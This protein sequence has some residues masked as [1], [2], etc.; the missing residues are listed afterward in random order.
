MSRRSFVFLVAGTMILFLFSVSSAVVP[1]KIN[2]QGKLATSGGGC[3]NDTVAMTFTIYSDDQGTVVDWT[4]DQDSVIVKEGIFNVLLGSVV[5]IPASVFDGSTKYLGV[6]VES[7]PEMRPLKPMVS[8]AYAYKSIETDTADFAWMA[9][10]ADLLDGQHAS[11]FLSTANDYGRSGVATDLYEETTT[12]TDKYVNE[13][14]PETVN[15]TSGTAFTG[16][17]S[18]SS[19]SSMYG[20]KGYAENTS[21]GGAYGGRFETESSGTGAHYGIEVLSSGSSSYGTYGVAGYVENSSDGDVYGGYFN[22]QA[23][24]TGTSY[25]VYS[26]SYN[27]SGGWHYGVYGWATNTSTGY[28]K[29]GYFLA[30]STGTGHPVGVWGE[31]NTSTSGLSYGIIGEASN[32]SS[33]RAVGGL[34]YTPGPIGIGGRTGIE[35]SV[36]DS[37]EVSTYGIDCLSSNRST[38]TVYGGYFDAS[39][40]LTGTGTRYGI[41]ASA[42]ADYG[43]AGYFSGDVRIT[44]SLVVL[45]GKSAAVK[46]DNGEYRLLYS[47]ESPEVW[48]E[49][50]GEGRLVNGKAVIQID[51]LFAQTVN[52]SVKYHVFLTPQDEPLTLA[53]A[54]RT[55]ASFEVIGPSG[56]NI[57]FSYRIVAKRKGYEDIRLAKMGKPT[58]EEVALEQEKHQAEREEEQAKMEEQREE[59]KKEREKME[60]ENTRMEQEREQR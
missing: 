57:P 45:G 24:G 13:T 14:G 27:S 7:D 51:P 37:S 3:L 33:G 5:S 22:S 6:Q 4:E 59:M 34:F 23:L 60:A 48:F 28:P 12:L 16:C 49:D 56:A 39:G 9:E 50:F 41:Y 53:V 11:D 40:Y 52:T 54:N 58:P 25:G 26:K 17:A 44:D 29:G 30:N 21:D 35:I 43:W 18:G 38:G 15:A 42:S 1:D 10:N 2:Y 36:P 32:G 31:G 55:T 46:V 47:Q 8:V 20:I 19:A